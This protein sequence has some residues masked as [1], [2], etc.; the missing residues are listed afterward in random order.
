MQ[1]WLIGWLLVWF[2][3]GKVVVG[4][5]KDLV[6]SGRKLIIH[7][8]IVNYIAACHAQHDIIC[9]DVHRMVM[10]PQ[11]PRGLHV[12]VN[13]DFHPMNGTFGLWTLAV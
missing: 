12:L 6:L 9:G 2:G 13:I 5:D 1:P 8:L 11:I 7:L 3:V 10:V 4:D